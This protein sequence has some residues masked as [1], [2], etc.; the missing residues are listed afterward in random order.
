MTMDVNNDDY[1]FICGSRNPI[2][3]NVKPRMDADGK[4]ACFE[5]RLPNEYQGWQGMAHGGMIAALLDEV[6]AYAAMTVAEPIVTASLNV[7]YLKPVP[8][9][10]L[11]TARARVSMQKG[12]SI[13]TEAELLLG[14]QVMASAEG[15]L[16][17]IKQQNRE[18]RA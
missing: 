1:C 16:V 9:G 2:G 14:D 6:S 13:M 5:V 4:R 10:E 12:R 18:N 17:V 3:L 11:I 7:R 8:V 15:R